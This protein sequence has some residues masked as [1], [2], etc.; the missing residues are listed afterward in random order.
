MFAYKRTTVN[1]DNMDIDNAQNI[2][3]GK[4]ICF[5]T[6]EATTQ[7]TFK[8]KKKKLCI[9][10]TINE[11]CDSQCKNRFFFTYVIILIRLHV[12]LS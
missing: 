11:L 9:E 4:S 5:S 2:S 7:F 10:V 8:R 1:I 3:S 12:C 6:K